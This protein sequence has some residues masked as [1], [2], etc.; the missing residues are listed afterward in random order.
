M[1]RMQRFKAERDDKLH[2]RS[3]KKEF[4]GCAASMIARK[5]FSTQFPNENSEEIETAQ[6]FIASIHSSTVPTC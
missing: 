1:K 6:I 3:R 5:S 2:K 4:I